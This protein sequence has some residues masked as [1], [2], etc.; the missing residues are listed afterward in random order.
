MVLPLWAWPTIRHL[1]RRRP[2]ARVRVVPYQPQRDLPDL[3]DP[4]SPRPTMG[5]GADLGERAAGAGVWPRPGR[6]A[7]TGMRS[8]RQ[9]DK[10]SAMISMLYI[11][12][13][14]SCGQTNIPILVSHTF[15]QIRMHL[16]DLAEPKRSD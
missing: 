14:A 16:D 9:L 7:P 10:V 15:N 13:I 8:I 11:G 6:A 12:F 1:R 3:A 4:R 5:R 2:F